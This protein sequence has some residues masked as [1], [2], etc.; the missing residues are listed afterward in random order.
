MVLGVAA[1][2]GDGR[3]DSSSGSGAVAFCKGDYHDA[4][5]VKRNT[6]DLHI[7]NIFGGFNRGAARALH[8]LS[9]LGPPTAL[10]TRVGRHL[11]SSRTGDSAS[12][13]ISS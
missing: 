11:S 3:W 4:I 6:V 10:N 7:H 12:L 1:R 2:E 8:A 13:L 5:H 9:P